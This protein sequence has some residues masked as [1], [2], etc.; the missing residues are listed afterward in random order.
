VAP[1]LRSLRRVAIAGKL[2][3]PLARHPRPLGIDTIVGRTTHTQPFGRL[4]T[5][6]L[7]LP[8][9]DLPPLGEAEGLD[10]LRAMCLSIETP[11]LAELAGRFL[12]TRLGGRLEHVEL[13]CADLAAA[14]AEPWGRIAARDRLMSLGLRGFVAGWRVVVVRQR[15]AVTVQFGEPV[16]AGPLDPRPIEH[17]IASLGQ[18]ISS[19]TLELVGEVPA[20]TYSQFAVH[21]L[22]RRFSSVTLASSRRWR[23]P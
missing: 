6:G 22:Q 2:L 23:S 5:G 12:R 20:G 21:E 16:A 4:A 15:G 7:A 8:A 1:A 3:E 10:R 14:A 11:V 13:F 9:D 19:A 18:G 17:L